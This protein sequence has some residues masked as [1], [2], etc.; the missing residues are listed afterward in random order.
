MDEELGRDRS[1]PGADQPGCADGGRDGERSADGVTLGDETDSGADLTSFEQRM[2]SDIG[3][4]YSDVSEE[5]GPP[6]Q[7]SGEDHDEQ[8][9]N[10]SNNHSYLRLTGRGQCRGRHAR[11]PSSTPVGPFVPTSER[12]Y[13]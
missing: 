10:T 13:Q 6:Q 3:R 5:G 12:G 11:W 8:N 4:S 9:G 2:A 7:T 1:D